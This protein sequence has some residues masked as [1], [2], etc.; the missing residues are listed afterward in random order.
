MAVAAPVPP[1]CTVSEPQSPRRSSPVMKAIPW[2]IAIVAIVAV[3]WWLNRPGPEESTTAVPSSSESEPA[4]GAETD[5][6]PEDAT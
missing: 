5:V 3:A 6:T 1:R 4:P 2:G